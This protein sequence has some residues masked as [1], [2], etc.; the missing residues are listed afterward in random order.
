M[1]I[2][3]AQKAQILK[4]YQRAAADTGSPEVQLASLRALQS[5]REPTLAD[6]V[7]ERWPAA[8]IA[9]RPAMIDFLLTRSEWS[10]ALAQ[11]LAA[12]TIASSHLDAARRARLLRHADP[13][14]RTLVE[15]ALNQGTPTNDRAKVVAAY[16]PALA[17]AGD[18]D[19]GRTH[20]DTR[21]ASC[22]RR[23]I[24]G[25]DLGPDLISVIQHSPEKLLV[26]ILDPNADVQ[27]GY[28][29]FTGT[30]ADG[31]EVYGLIAAETANSLLIKLAN[32][33]VR[34]LLRSEMTSLRGSDL[35]LMPDGLE[36]GLTIQDL[37]DLIAFLRSPI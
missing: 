28:H 32:G 22:H 12:R 29:A 5:C 17:L 31:E 4:D 13:T 14:V 15:K 36:V 9:L 24:E 1:A 30:L 7:I 27:P 34:T 8:S 23:G 10:L 2:T 25:P 6:S 16:R 11:A 21:C 20:F 33:T 26:N 19:R 18:P 35:S 3:T 37:S